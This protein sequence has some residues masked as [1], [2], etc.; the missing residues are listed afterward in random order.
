VLLG[1]GHSRR[2]RRNLTLF[3]SAA[4]AL[5]AL[6]NF[7]GAALGHAMLGTTRTELFTPTLVVTSVLGLAWYVREDQRFLPSSPL[8]V[9]R[10]TA[11]RP[12]LGPIVFGG[13]LGIGYLTRVIT[14]LVWIGLLLVV[15]RGSATWGLIYGVAFGLGRSLELVIQYNMPVESA[16]ER[17]ERTVFAQPRLLKPAAAGLLVMLLGGGL[18]AI[19]LGEPLTRIAF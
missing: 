5:A 16:S 3:S 7:A 10:H 4:V 19:V 1:G 14:P 13:I 9:A 18:S 17:L 2:S 11:E 8:Q 12:L 15:V 6:V